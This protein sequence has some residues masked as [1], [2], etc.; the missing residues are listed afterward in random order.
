[1]CFW[2]KQQQQQNTQKN[3]NTTTKQKIKPKK[4]LSGSWNWTRDLSHPKWMR[5]PCTT[6][7]T[8]SNDGLI[9][10][11]LF[12]CFDASSVSKGSLEIIP[13]DFSPLY[14]PYTLSLRQK[15]RAHS[16]N[17]G[18]YLQSLQIIPFDNNNSITL[19]AKIFRSMQKKCPT[20]H[21]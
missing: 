13:D 12:N 2:I 11:K 16:F 14:L 20:P 17:T 6:E 18:R 4:T 15:Q 1:M 10:V 3:K 7:S 5:Y 19:N 8:E 21:C 9:V